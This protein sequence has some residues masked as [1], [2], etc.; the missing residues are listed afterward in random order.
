[1]LDSRCLYLLSVI[2]IYV[3]KRTFCHLLLTNIYLPNK[4][5]YGQDVVQF[6][7]K[8][9]KSNLYSEVSFWLLSCLTKAKE[10]NLSYNF[11]I[12]GEDLLADEFMS[13]PRSFAQSENR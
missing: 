1:M 5:T 6:H 2:P 11:T 3:V 8:Q 7:F 13:S 9:S 10:F 12:T 4:S